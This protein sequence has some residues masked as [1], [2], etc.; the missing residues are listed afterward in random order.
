MSRHDFAIINRSFWPEN[1][2]IGE[3]L[4][5]VAERLSA[6]HRVCVIAQSTL[7]LKGELI[8]RGRGNGIA[9]AACKAWSDSGSNLILRVVD[10]FVFVAWVVYSLCLYRPRKIYVATDPPIVVPFAVV[11]LAFFLRAKV[12]YHVQDI[13]PEAANIVVALPGLAFKVL[14]AVD[15]WVMRNSSKLI[16]LSND[17]ATQ[18]HD[19]SGTAV[20]IQIIDNPGA[21]LLCGMSAVRE[22]GFIY[23]GNLGRLQRVPLLIDAI[24]EYCSLGGVLPFEFVGGGVY[25]DQLEALSK[26]VAGVSYRGYLPAKI[27][28][29]RVA[30]YKWAI[31]SINDEVTRYAFPSKSSTYAIASTRILAVCGEATS[32]ARWVMAHKFGRVS[33][34]TVAALVAVFFEIEAEIGG[35]T[36][37]RPDL[38]FLTMG[39]FVRSLAQAI[40]E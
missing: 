31:L 28:A 24:T 11:A 37:D 32:V 5:Q 15:S 9:F 35:E 36:I 20:P 34:P 23:C 25:A 19:R 2:V 1:Q 8:R 6:E 21:E 18:I 29:E 4:L 10:T 38:Q 7:N 30:N 17:M 14:K 12:I 13:H 26:K 3:A 27:A 39:H 22:K 33:E 16:T 40:V